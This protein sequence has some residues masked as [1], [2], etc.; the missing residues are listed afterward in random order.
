MRDSLSSV[1]AMISTAFFVAAAGLMPFFMLEPTFWLIPAVG[2]ILGIA[3]KSG[4]FPR[5]LFVPL[6]YWVAGALLVDALL[7]LLTQQ[8]T[9]LFIFTVFF[10]RG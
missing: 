9:L 7:L 6:G 3:M 8:S 2:L 5:R 4:P 10:G 1:S